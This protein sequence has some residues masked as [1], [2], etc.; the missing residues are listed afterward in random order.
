V[1]ILPDV[2]ARNLKVVFC[3][4]AVGTQSAER[5]AYYA[6]NGNKFWPTLYAVGITDRLLQPREYPTLLS[7]RAGL[8]DLAKRVSG[9]DSI[10]KQTDFDRARL[11]QVIE[12]YQPFA[13]AFTSKTAGQSFFGGKR[14]YGRQPEIIGHTRIYILPSPSGLANGYWSETWWKKLAADIRNA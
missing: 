4:T 6:G 12:T 9:P 1:H 10:I 7:Y 2:L 8:T 3:G 14:N 5:K 11:R 13:L